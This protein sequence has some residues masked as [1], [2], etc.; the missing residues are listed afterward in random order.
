MYYHAMENESMRSWSREGIGCRHEESM[1][2][3]RQCMGDDWY[4]ER[5]VKNDCCGVRSM[6]SW[7]TG[8]MVRYRRMEN[9]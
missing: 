6:E 8:S 4:L 3:E 2:K 7:M 5:R 9:M 1:R